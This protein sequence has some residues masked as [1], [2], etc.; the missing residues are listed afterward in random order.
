MEEVRSINFSWP[1]IEGFV[2]K[3]VD[4]IESSG[5]KPDCLMGITVGGL[6]P[7][8]LVAEKMDIHN[9]VTV[10]AHS[11]EKR[12]QGMLNITSLPEADLKGKNVVLIDDIA[13]TG[14]TLKE[15]S[16]V[17]IERYEVRGLKTA[18]LC[19]DEKKCE[20]PPDFSAFSKPPQW[21]IFPWEEE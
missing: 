16:R 2:E 3:L 14:K 21:I 17:I 1:E 6:V 13:D 15:I 11:Y 10:S 20:F 4:E 18:A 5:F 12:E 8:A 7:L 9:V 19:V